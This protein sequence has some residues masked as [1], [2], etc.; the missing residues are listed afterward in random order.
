MLQSVIN[1]SYPDLLANC[2]SLQANQENWNF[3]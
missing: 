2:E 3:P 1:P